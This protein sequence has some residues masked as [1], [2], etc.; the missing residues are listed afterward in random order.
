[1]VLNKLL[2]AV[3]REGLQWDCG[4]RVDALTKGERKEQIPQKFPNYLFLFQTIIAYIKLLPSRG[5]L[6]DL[7]GR[8]AGHPDDEVGY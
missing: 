6:C 5:G 8:V 3:G 1:M 7:I 2:C 4:L